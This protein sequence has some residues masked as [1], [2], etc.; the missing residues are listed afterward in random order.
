MSKLGNKSSE[1]LKRI[2]ENVQNL[3]TQKSDINYR[4]KELFIESKSVGFDNK[5]VKKLIRAAK[6][7]EKF[8]EELE[9]L[10]IYSDD[11]QL[12]LF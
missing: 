4:I 11:I 10:E 2:V 12:N 9:L 5:I 1:H 8:K 6:D 7:P 3:E